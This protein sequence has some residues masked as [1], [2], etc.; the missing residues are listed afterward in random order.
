MDA[1]LDPSEILNLLTD[2]AEKKVMNCQKL[3]SSAQRTI[4]NLQTAV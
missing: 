2:L 4:N 3:I 1:Q